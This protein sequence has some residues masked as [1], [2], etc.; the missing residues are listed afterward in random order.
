MLHSERQIVTEVSVRESVARPF[1]YASES[2]VG[3]VIHASARAKSKPEKLLFLS[4]S[5]LIPPLKLPLCLV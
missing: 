2:P 1:R 4:E 5:N 3:G